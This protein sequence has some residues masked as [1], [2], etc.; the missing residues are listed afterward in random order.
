MSIQFDGTLAVPD[1]TGYTS[2]VFS[3]EGDEP[4]RLNSR[5]RSFTGLD[6]GTAEAGITYHSVASPFTFTIDRPALFKTLG[7]VDPVTG[8]LTTIPR[9]VWKFRTR[10]GVVPLSGQPS[11]TAIFE[12]RCSIPAGSEIADPENIRAGLAAH[13]G[14]LQDLAAQ[15]G[16][17]FIDGNL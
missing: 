15:L 13:I 8:S 17:L 7:P 14:E 9:N 12:T 11:E 10:K 5:Q 16:D 3:N 4:V 1:M 2:A 6:S